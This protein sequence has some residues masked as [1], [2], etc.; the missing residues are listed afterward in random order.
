MK[1]HYQISGGFAIFLS[2]V[3]Y[4]LL[5]VSSY[6]LVATTDLLFLKEFDFSWQ[7][8]VIASLISI[9]VMIVAYHAL[10]YACRKNNKQLFVLFFLLFS[11]VVM[12][13]PFYLRYYLGYDIMS[14]GCREMFFW[15][16][17]TF[18]VSLT[19]FVIIRYGL[20]VAHEKTLIDSMP[21]FKD[22]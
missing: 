8:A 13:L 1:K 9:I 20:S 6:F 10:S 12:I 16:Y 19:L 14:I 17:M 7:T 22:R 21:S 3:L 18:Y 4:L 15:G 5:L 2:I 11:I